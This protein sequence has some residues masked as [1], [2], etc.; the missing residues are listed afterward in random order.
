MRIDSE[1]ILYG[2]CTTLA[3]LRCLY[4]TLGNP[5]DRP[6]ILGEVQELA[7]QHAPSAIAR[8]LSAE[9]NREAVARPTMRFVGAMNRSPPMLRGFGFRSNEYG[10]TC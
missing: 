6:R 8:A 4:M 5:G 9:G 10:F 1:L 3:I 2:A 7:R